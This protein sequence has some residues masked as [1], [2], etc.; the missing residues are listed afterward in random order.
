MPKE[1][2]DQSPLLLQLKE[3]QYRLEE[4]N[5]QLEL[6]NQVGIMLTSELE[7]DKLVQKV[8]DLATQI[9]KAQFG[10]LFYKKVNEQGEEHTL[11]TLSGADK[12][13]FTGMHALRNTPLLAPTFNGEGIIRS[14]DITKDPRYGQNKPHHGMPKGHLPLKSYMALP[15]ISRSGTVLGGLFFGHIQSGVFTQYEEELLKGIAAQAAVAIDNARLFESNLEAEQ[16]TK[17]VLE[18]IP[19]LAWTALPNGYINYFNKRWYEYSGLPVEPTKGEEWQSIMH[20]DDLENTGKIWQQAM[21][22]GETFE[23]EIRLKRAADNSYRWHL[24][25]ATVVKDTEG[26]ILFWVGTCTDVDDVKKAQ[27]SLIKKNEELSRINQDLD[28][29]VYTAS[30]D[31]KTPV[32]HIQQLIQVLHE[33]AQFQTADA[34]ILQ[35]LL[36]KSLKQLQHTIQDLSEIVKVQKNQ[37][38]AVE[39]L[40]LAQII[41][42]VKVSLQ[43]AI[44]ETDAKI[45]TRL[46]QL[47]I[48]PFSRVNLKSILYNLISNGL[49]YR[50]AKRTP[51]ITVTSSLQPGYYKVSVSDNGLGMDLAQRGHKLFQMFSRFHDHVPGSGIGLYIVNRI[52]KNNGGYIEVESKLDEGTTFNLF[53]KHGIETEELNS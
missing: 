49:K 51:E 8:T 36:D 48:L 12:E 43:V 45:I 35:E 1:L 16:R 23:I 27:Q 15:V 40:E 7:L 4:K 30:H 34:E 53:F 31:L 26:K 2:F 14:D 52:I 3:A 28:N 42:E 47:P 10:A 18:S 21:D 17:L 33:Q 29:F 46:E 5:K 38:A 11:Y 32:I 13:D 50:S 41:E 24:T 20:P 19:L 6:I 39:K 44:S 37:E 9:S 25:R 22:T